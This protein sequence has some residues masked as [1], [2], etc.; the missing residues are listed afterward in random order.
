MMRA[1]R[2]IFRS[3]EAAV[4]FLSFSTK[5]ENVY[6]NKVFML[7]QQKADDGRSVPQRDVFGTAALSTAISMGQLWII[8]LARN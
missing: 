2:L 5:C 3:Q 4:R 6:V 7:L 8:G 1:M